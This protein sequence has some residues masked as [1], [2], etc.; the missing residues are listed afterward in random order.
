MSI[1]TTV[2]GQVT[3]VT[4]NRPEKRNALSKGMYL[5]LA[6]AFNTVSTP[7]VVLTGSGGAFTAGN[8]LGD[9]LAHEAGD[10][11]K[12]PARIFQEALLATR[13]VV[14]A[15][16]D[17]PA[18]GIGATLLLHC[19]LVYATERSYLQFPFVPLGLVPEFG[20]SYALPRRVGPQRATEL[21]LFGERLP[22]AEAAQLGL[23]NE[24]LED[25]T[26]LRKRVPERAATLATRSMR[27]LQATRAL[28]HDRTDTSVEARMDS[29]TAHFGELLHDPDTVA[30]L[31]AKL[32]R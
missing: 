17:G 29:E 7:I 32:S 23:V 25:S 27:A 12:T 10:R 3:T 9:F 2:D 28:L 31:R 11:Q 6:E 20:S 18:V 16:V 5:A 24:V 26:A 14:L 4:I 22:A 1:E 8:D 19:D 15:S 13:A 30:T 21:L